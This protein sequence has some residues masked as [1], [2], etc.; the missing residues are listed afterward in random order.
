MTRYEEIIVINNFDAD[1]FLQHYWQQKPL[2]IRQAIPDIQSPLSPDELAGL[3][4]EEEVESRIVVNRNGNYELAHGPFDEDVF[5]SLPD[6]DWTLLVQAVDHYDPDVAK[7]LDY[8]RFIPNWRIDDIMVS[9]APV[10]GG[11]PA[12]VDNYDVFLLQGAGTRQWQ[13]G[14]KSDHKSQIQ[15]NEQLRLLL[16]F[17]V[18]EEWVL[19]PGDMLYVPPGYGHRGTSLDNDCMTYS[20]GFRAPS[21]SEMLSDFCDHQISLLNEQDRYSDPQLK[22]QQHPGEITD[23]TIEKIQSLLKHFTEDKQAI[24]EWFGRFMTSEK[25][26]EDNDRSYEINN[27]SEQLLQHEYLYR[28]NSSRFAYT[29][30]NGSA[31]LYVNGEAYNSSLE[32]A[33]LLANNDHYPTPALPTDTQSIKLIQQLIR[34]GSLYIEETPAN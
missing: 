18:E 14:P 11:I 23:A 17:Q 33:L 30:S 6:K 24:A 1:D 16:D 2:L 4:C 3:A 29:Q 28:D 25:Y 19:N 12:H 27:Y 15:D 9:Y 32:T 22:R 26:P 31:T 21:Y 20:I 10:N 34:Q 13:L 5:T 8:F 7:L